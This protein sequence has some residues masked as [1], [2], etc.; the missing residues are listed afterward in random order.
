MQLKTNPRPYQFHLDNT[1]QESIRR[2]TCGPYYLSF[3]P[4][5]CDGSWDVCRG[6]RD[7]MD[8]FVPACAIVNQG[9]HSRLFFWLAEILLLLLK[10]I[11]R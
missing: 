3:H 9:A 2:Q 4:L 8:C 5:F 1:V 6:K 11:G 7:L 10:E